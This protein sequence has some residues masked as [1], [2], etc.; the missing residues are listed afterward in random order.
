LHV[1]Y[2]TDGDDPANDVGEVIVAAGDRNKVNVTVLSVVP[3]GPPT[4]AH[5]PDVLQSKET[6]QARADRAAEAAAARL[7]QAGFTV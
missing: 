4:V 1:L 2:A 5:L 6:L 7:T 3:T